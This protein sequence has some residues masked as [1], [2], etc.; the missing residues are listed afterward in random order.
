MCIADEALR[1][2]Q[3]KPGL[4]LNRAVTWASASVNQL[5][6]VAVNP[7]HVFKTDRNVAMARERLMTAAD[8]G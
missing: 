5:V 4:P 3:Q 6:Y 7:A 1:L 2:M 8:S